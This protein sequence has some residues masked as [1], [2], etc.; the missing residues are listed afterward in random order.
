MSKGEDYEVEFFDLKRA[1]K[2][3]RISLICVYFNP[4][5][6][7]G[8]YVARLWDCDRPTQIMATAD[9][10]EGIRAKIP[11]TMV[12]LDRDHRDDPVIVET[13]I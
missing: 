6:Y 8:K 9:T 1:A 4:R 11:D 7:P 12:K 3:T 2:L 5:D 13:W 10:L